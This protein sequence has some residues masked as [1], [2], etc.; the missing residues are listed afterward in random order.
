M[1]C[2][3]LLYNSGFTMELQNTERV[4]QNKEVSKNFETEKLLISDLG[5]LLLLASY[6]NIHKNLNTSESSYDLSID[7]HCRKALD[8]TSLKYQSLFSEDFIAVY[9]YDNICNNSIE[10]NSYNQQLINYLNE[11]I[12]TIMLLTFDDFENLRHNINPNITLKDLN[13]FRIGIINIMCQHNKIEELYFLKTTNITSIN[14][15][16][17]LIK[18]QEHK[19]EKKFMNFSTRIEIN[20]EKQNN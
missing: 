7:T 16:Q 19:Q 12:K 13:N 4:E 2:L 9:A 8:I 6:N 15:L 18:E 11:N 10:K 17:E 20:F 14:E 3:I 1:F 5:S